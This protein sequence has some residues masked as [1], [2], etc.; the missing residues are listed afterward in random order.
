MRMQSNWIFHTLL[1]GMQNDTATLREFGSFIQN[2][3]HLLCT[4]GTSHLSTYT[5]ETKICVHAKICSRPFTAILFIT[6]KNENHQMSIRRWT[7]KQIV[8]IHKMEYYTAM[9]TAATRSWR[10]PKCTLQ[11]ERSQTKRLATV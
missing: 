3:T 8:T 1:V 6:D 9:K 2:K 4:L 10:N 7:D 11:S 5:K